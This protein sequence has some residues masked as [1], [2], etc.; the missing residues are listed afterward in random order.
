MSAVLA[1]VIKLAPDVGP[2][3]RGWRCTCEFEETVAED[4]ERLLGVEITPV[5][6]EQIVPGEEMEVELRLWAPLARP[7][8][9]RTTVRFYEGALLVA[10][11]RVSRV[12]RQ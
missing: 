12:V 4:G 7:P 1:A 10:S 2:R 11:G 6:S 9:P 5:Q 3:R 8:E